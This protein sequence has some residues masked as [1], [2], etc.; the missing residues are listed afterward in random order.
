MITEQCINCFSGLYYVNWKSPATNTKIKQWGKTKDITA[1]IFFCSYKH[2]VWNKLFGTNGD[3]LFK[4]YIQRETHYWNKTKNVKNLM[5]TLWSGENILDTVWATCRERWHNYDRKTKS[6][7]CT[8]QCLWI[9]H[10]YI[11]Y[12]KMP[13]HLYSR[14]RAWRFEEVEV[15]RGARK[16]ARSTVL[17]RDQ[18]GWLTVCHAWPSL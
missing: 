12:M 2:N 18:G 3:K 7:H 8:S 4:T 14:D 13:Y 5:L 9:S 16:R 1:R 6:L 10:N 11:K 17:L 15:G